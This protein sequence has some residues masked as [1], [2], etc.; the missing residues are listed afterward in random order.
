MLIVEKFNALKNQYLGILLIL[1]F[2]P[3]SIEVVSLSVFTFN[4][5]VKRM[6]AILC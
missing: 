4:Q 2:T 3:N 1:A 5:R 6:K